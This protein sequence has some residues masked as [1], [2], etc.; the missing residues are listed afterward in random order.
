MTCRRQR[1]PVD[2][3]RAVLAGAS[4]RRLRR[5]PD[6]QIHAAIASSNTPILSVPQPPAIFPE[7][8]GLAPWGTGRERC[9][10]L[11]LSYKDSGVPWLGEVPEHWEVRRYRADRCSG[12]WKQV[13]DQ[14]NASRACPRPTE[15]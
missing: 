7:G 8:A 15:P 3:C 2:A 1:G 9:E 5:E 13:I 11:A 10:P 12:K 4:V 14:G 6:P